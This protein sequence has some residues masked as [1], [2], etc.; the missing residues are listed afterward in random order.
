MN[1]SMFQHPTKDKVLASVLTPGKP[2]VQHDMS[3]TLVKQVL[4]PWETAEDGHSGTPPSP[5]RQKEGNLLHE[6]MEE[7]N[8]T[9]EN[10]T[11]D[12]PVRRP[13]ARRCK[14]MH[15]TDT[16]RSTGSH[17]SRKKGKAQTPPA[18]SPI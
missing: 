10:E 2:E 13:L 1:D 17:S 14:Q 18:N 16:F 15:L 6:T 7:A 9:I 8:L 3:Q 11:L 4:D 5:N 12:S